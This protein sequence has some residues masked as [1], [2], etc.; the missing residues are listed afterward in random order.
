MLPEEHGSSADPNYFSTINHR[1]SL[2]CRKALLVLNTRQ[3]REEMVNVLFHCCSV[4]GLPGGGFW[5]SLHHPKQ[6]TV[7]NVLWGGVGMSD[8]QI[9]VCS[10]HCGSVM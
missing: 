7:W 1:L 6:S 9:H 4:L 3:V 2:L 8:P 5:G 10:D